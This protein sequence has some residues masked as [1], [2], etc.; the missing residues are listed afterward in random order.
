MIGE[1]T[2]RARD[3]MLFA[4]G[5]A[6]SRG[7]GHV[8]TE[9][10][11][12]GLIGEGSGVAIQALTRLGVDLERVRHD[13]DKIVGAGGGAESRLPLPYTPRTVEVLK[14]AL[15]EAREHRRQP[16]TAHLLLGLVREDNGIAGQ[17]LATQ[18]LELFQLRKVVD[19]IHGASGGRGETGG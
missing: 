19:D 12:L 8:G 13:I 2:S 16:G 1:F 4:F 14:R 9:H 11:L 18:G 3:V 10:V 5:S 7:H 15:D 6:H 17:V